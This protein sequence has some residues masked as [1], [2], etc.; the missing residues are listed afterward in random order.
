MRKKKRNSLL[1]TYANVEMTKH[2][3]KSYTKMKREVELLRKEMSEI[4]QELQFRNGTDRK[5]KSRLSPD[6]TIFPISDSSSSTKKAKYITIPF[7]DDEK[8]K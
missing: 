6:V 2:K 5:Q 8:R 1:E 7:N 4:K 3:G